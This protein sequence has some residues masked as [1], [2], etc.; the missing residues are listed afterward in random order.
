MSPDDDEDALALLDRVRAE[1]QLAQELRSRA[2][3]QRLVAAELRR[4]SAEIRI[5][6]S[7][8]DT[9]VAASSSTAN[10]I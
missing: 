5:R 6:L 7:S 10:T 9:C 1:H 4:Q 3:E 2:V 8:I